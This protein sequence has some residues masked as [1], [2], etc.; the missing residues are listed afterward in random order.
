MRFQKTSLSAAACLVALCGCQSWNTGYPIQSPARVPP[1]GTGSFQT[2]SP[3]Y[4]GAGGNVSQNFL[5]ASPGYGVPQS[6]AAPA[7]V[8]PATF[9]AP[10][11][12]PSAVVPANQFSPVNNAGF[13]GTSQGSG[14]TSNFNDTGSNFRWQN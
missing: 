4:N 2:S 14:T 7:P 9:T 13:S 12:Q 10:P 5:T 3:Y 11:S 8:Q 6:Y 1:P